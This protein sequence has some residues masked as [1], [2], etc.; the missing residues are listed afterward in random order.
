[1]VR[2][3]DWA[4]WAENFPLK[5]ECEPADGGLPERIILSRAGQTIYLSMEEL[6]AVVWREPEAPKLDP[7]PWVY[8]GERRKDYV[9]TL[10]YEAVLKPREGYSQNREDYS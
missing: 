4:T 8:R 1:M 9:F 5:V 7:M 10:G 3:F 2:K 6:S